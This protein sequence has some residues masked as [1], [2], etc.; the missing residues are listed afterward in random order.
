M[1]ESGENWQKESGLSS[2]I[3]LQKL[4]SPWKR[5]KFFLNE[6]NYTWFSLRIK[7]NIF[8]FFAFTTI[9]LTRCVSQQIGIAPGRPFLLKHKTDLPARMTV[10]DHNHKDCELPTERS[11]QGNTLSWAMTFLVIFQTTKLCLFHAAYNV[12]YACMHNYRNFCWNNDTVFFFLFFSF[13]STTQTRIDKQTRNLRCNSCVLAAFSGS[14][15]A[16]SMRICLS[17]SQALWEKTIYCFSI[18]NA[19]TNENHSY[20]TWLMYLGKEYLAIHKRATLSSEGPSWYQT[21]SS[22]S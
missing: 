16:C 8:G 5:K 19:L 14:G 4:L 2:P 22:N 10:S 15:L 9:I 3:W 18:M 21:S 1:L 17:L 6:I 11:E 7:D 12:Q 20:D 13:N